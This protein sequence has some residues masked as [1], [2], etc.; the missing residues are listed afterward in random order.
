MICNALSSPVKTTCQGF[1]PN[2][3]PVF[4]V[5]CYWWSI[6]NFLRLIHFAIAES[7]KSVFMLYEIYY[8]YTIHYIW[9]LDSD[10]IKYLLIVKSGDT[11][12]NLRYLDMSAD[13]QID[14]YRYY[15]S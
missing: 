14:T 2:Q 6:R 3:D 12:S 9:S 8:I 13:H 10:R 15:E 7:L 1:L 4:A 11:I 5:T